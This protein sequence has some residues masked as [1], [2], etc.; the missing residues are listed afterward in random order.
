MDNLKEMLLNKEVEAVTCYIT[1]NLN[2]TYYVLADGTQI[3]FGCENGYRT[4][5]HR[6]MFA[7][8]DNL[9]YND[10]ESLLKNTGMIGYTPES[11]IA[12][13]L[14]NQELTS[15]QQDFIDMYNV[16]LLRDEI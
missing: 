5:D 7:M 2:A 16:D 14:R 11:N 6:A 3:S 15:Q 12:W 9:E 10:F 8:F 1:N 13:C 4:D